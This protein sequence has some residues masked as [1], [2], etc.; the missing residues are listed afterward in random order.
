MFNRGVAKAQRISFY[1]EGY[2]VKETQTAFYSTK[3]KRAFQLKKNNFVD[4]YFDVCF[5]NGKCTRGK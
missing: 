2:P 4:K 5:T 1:K 3:V